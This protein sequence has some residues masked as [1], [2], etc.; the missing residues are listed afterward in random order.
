MKPIILAICLLLSSF[1]IAQEFPTSDRLE[2]EN[3]FNALVV[4]KKLSEVKNLIS[5]AP[6]KPFL[7]GSGNPQVEHPDDF[8]E[9]V[10]KCTSKEKEYQT[11]LGLKVVCAEVACENQG[12]YEYSEKTITKVQLILERP[13]NPEEFFLKLMEAYGDAMI[14]MDFPVEGATV[15]EW[16][17]SETLMSAFTHWQIE[18]EKFNTDYF[19]IVFVS[20]YGG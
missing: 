10:Y 11:F 14:M 4:H 6:V 18:P 5:P 16:A 19:C 12:D 15:M 7:E 8:T 13:E 17:G 3:G 20:S 2:K 1:A 9:E